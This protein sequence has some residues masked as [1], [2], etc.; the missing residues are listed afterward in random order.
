MTNRD[1]AALAILRIGLGVF[2]LM[3]SI[4]KIVAPEA[5][6]RIFEHFY[7]ASISE[8]LAPIVGVVEGI[9]SLA[10]VFGVWKTLSY[11][12]G[13]L[14]HAISTVSS[15]PQLLSPFGENH[16]FIAGIPVLAAF[17]ALF[18]LRHH[19]TRW[20]LGGG[21]EAAGADPGGA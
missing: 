4:D 18:L 3:W 8:T 5:T 1:R 6:V 15:L 13:L 7:K 2:L 20:T 21:G 9:L 19:D 14:I 17:V 10:I 12:L 16:L 11:G